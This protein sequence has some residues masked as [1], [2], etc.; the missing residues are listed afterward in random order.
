MPRYRGRFLRKK[1]DKKQPESKADEVCKIEVVHECEC[2]LHKVIVSEIETLFSNWLN[3]GYVDKKNIIRETHVHEALIT[4]ATE[5][6][7]WAFAVKPGEHKSRLMNGIIT[8]IIKEYSVLTALIENGDRSID[9]IRAE[10]TAKRKK[11]NA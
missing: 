11:G 10:L 4:I 2:S 7:R 9:K 1:N 5:Q 6:K 8:P 3:W